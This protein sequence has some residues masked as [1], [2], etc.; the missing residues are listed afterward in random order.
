MKVA[1]IQSPIVA[2]NHRS[3]KRSHDVLVEDR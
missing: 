2:I 3:Y 1:R